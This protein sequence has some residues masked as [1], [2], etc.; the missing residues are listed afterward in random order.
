MQKISPPFPSG[1]P[2]L[3]LDIRRKESERERQTQTK[4]D[5][6]SPSRHRPGHVLF[7]S[8][9]SSSSSG[10]FARPYALLALPALRC[11]PSKFSLRFRCL[12]EGFC[13]RFFSAKAGVKDPKE[14]GKLTD[15]SSSLTCLPSSESF[16]C[17]SEKLLLRTLV[18][19][20]LCVGPGVGLAG[21][22]SG[23]VSGWVS[24][25]L[26]ERDR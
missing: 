5:G 2:Y 7:S 3:F 14:R 4:S 6:K 21:N 20:V 13:F 11:P 19:Q 1:I 12:A 15:F 22:L 9:S 10:V 16:S 26:E 25:T 8:S 17:L 18:F 24:Q 23:S